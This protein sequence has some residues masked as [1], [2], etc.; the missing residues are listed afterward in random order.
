MIYKNQKFFILT[1]TLWM[2]LLTEQVQVTL[3]DGN[4]CK[5]YLFDMK[6]KTEMYGFSARFF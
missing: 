6:A 3:W 4:F 5:S 1:R 2:K